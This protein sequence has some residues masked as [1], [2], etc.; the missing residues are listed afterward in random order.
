MLTALKLL[1]QKMTTK[2]TN[3][4]HKL[5]CGHFMPNAG[6]LANIQIEGHNLL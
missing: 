2:Q 3:A 5:P 1:I 6:H 4:C